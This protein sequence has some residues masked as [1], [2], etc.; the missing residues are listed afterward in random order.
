MREL[1]ISLFRDAVETVVGNDKRRMKKEA[2]RGLLPLFLHMHD[3]AESVA[4]VGVSKL[5]SDTGKGVL[6]PWAQ[7]Q[8]L[9]AVRLWQ[10]ASPWCPAAQVTEDRAELPSVPA[11]VPPLPSSSPSASCCRAGRGGGV[12]PSYA[13]SIQPIQHSPE[14]GS[15]Q[16]Q[17]KQGQRSWHGH[18]QHL[19]CLLQQGPAAARGPRREYVRPC[20][21]PCC[22]CRCGRPGL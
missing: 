10:C 14:G 9:P 1:A 15:L 21:L 2:E 12:P 7:G 4:K 17:R 5:A 16:T 8:E 18:F 11:L 6:T 22:P 20:G 19:P 13:P 3:E